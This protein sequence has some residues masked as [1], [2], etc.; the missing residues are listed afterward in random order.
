ME[1]ILYFKNITVNNFSK[2]A[3]NILVA[4]SFNGLRK[5]HKDHD[6]VAILMPCK[7]KTRY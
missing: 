1:F 5:Y 3:F 2:T 7:I 6:H 4:P